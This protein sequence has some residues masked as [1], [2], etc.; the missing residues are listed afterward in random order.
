MLP[1]E[2]VVRVDRLAEGVIPARDE[3]VAVGLEVNGAPARIPPGNA[4]MSDPGAAVIAEAGIRHRVLAATGPANR[5][6]LTGT[7]TGIA[8][9]GT[10]A[11][12]TMACA[13]MIP[14][15][16]RMLRLRSWSVRPG[17]S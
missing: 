1:P 13:T 11:N 9:A 12:Q 8:R 4:T 15:W 10:L 14:R 16:M 3:P 17:E 5:D 7:V 6:V 2:T